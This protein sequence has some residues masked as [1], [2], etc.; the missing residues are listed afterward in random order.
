VAADLERALQ[1]VSDGVREIVLD[2]PFARALAPDHLRDATLL[3]PASGGKHLRSALL[4]WSCGALGGDPQ[5]ALPAAAAVE[6]YHTWTLAHDDIIDRD[7]LRRGGPS[8]HAAFRER[9]AELDAADPA[10]YGLSVAILAGD[11]QHA[12]AIELLAGLADRGPDPALVLRLVRDLEGPVLRAIAEG[13]TRDLQFAHQPVEAVSEDDILAMIA[14]KTGALFAFAAAA[15][16]AVARGAL[17]EDPQVAALRDFG[18]LAAIA[19]QLRDDVL[20]ITGAEEQLGK[21]IGSDIREGKRTTILRRAWIHASPDEREVLS[22]AL[23]RHDAD[24]A[25]A[26]AATEVLLRLGGVEHTEAL[27]RDHLHR[28]LQRLDALPAGRHRDLLHAL[29]AAMMDRS[30]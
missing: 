27:A 28:A 25:A 21:P 15:G 16:G 11:V 5:A 6:L 13:E 19:F 30:R 12:W 1:S 3:Y 22:R 2:S 9:A 7:D 18:R 10:H 4:L 23:G 24:P 17:D 26:A 20:G 8:L 14:C 29:A